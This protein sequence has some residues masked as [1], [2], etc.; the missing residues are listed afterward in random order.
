[1]LLLGF[2]ATFRHWGF[3]GKTT[4]FL[5]AVP[6]V[7]PAI[8]SVTKKLSIDRFIGNL[9]YPVYLNHFLVLQWTK[10]LAGEN[11]QL[12]FLLVNI[13]VLVLALLMQTMI[14]NPLDRWRQ[15][16]LQPTRPVGPVEVSA[17]GK[18][19]AVTRPFAE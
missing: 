10:E 17:A 16:R 5:V 15:T 4:L 14:E 13:V 6:F 7:I 9:S 8:F 19:S 11:G 12:P 1:M 18:W 3:P 2:V